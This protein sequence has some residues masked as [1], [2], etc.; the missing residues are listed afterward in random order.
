MSIGVEDFIPKQTLGFYKQ[1]SNA[2]APYFATEG[3]ACFDLFCNFEPTSKIRA[4]QSSS[5]QSIEL[6]PEFGRVDNPAISHGGLI[7]KG[8]QL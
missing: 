8:S 6:K 1:N 7:G 2:V 3:S 5:D 4:F